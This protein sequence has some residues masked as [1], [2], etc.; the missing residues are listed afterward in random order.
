MKSQT[1]WTVIPSEVETATQPPEATRPGFPSG[2][3]TFEAVPRDPS[4]WLRMTADGVLIWTKQSFSRYECRLSAS[5][6]SATRSAAWICRIKSA[7]CR[8]DAITSWEA[9]FASAISLSPQS[10]QE[11]FVVRFGR[12]QVIDE[13]F[14]R[15]ERRQRGHR[16]AQHEH[17]LPFLWMTKQFLESCSREHRVNRRIN[18][19]LLQPTVEMQ[20]HVPRAL[21]LFEDQFIHP[22]AG[23]GQRR[24]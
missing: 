19:F 6:S 9:D 22:A 17:A 3:A 14:H 13:F 10:A 1:D 11:Q 23:F 8:S 7:N 24:G 5:V 21:K 16:F 15:F 20:F 2:N 12:V 18:P 4:T